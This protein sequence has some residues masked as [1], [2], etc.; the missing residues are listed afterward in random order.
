[1]WRSFALLLVYGGKISLYTYSM[2]NSGSQIIVYEELVVT[3]QC[4]GWLICRSLVAR[5][6]CADVHIEQ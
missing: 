5:S 6:L 4:P 2:A 1:M 3:V